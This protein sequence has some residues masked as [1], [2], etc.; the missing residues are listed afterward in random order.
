MPCTFPLFESWAGLRSCVGIGLLDG[1]GFFLLSDMAFFCDEEGLA[2][3]VH[4][5]L[6][7]TIETFA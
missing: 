4:V 3:S 1:G 7:A 6:M 5:S 2:V